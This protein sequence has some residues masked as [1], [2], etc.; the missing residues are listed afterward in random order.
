MAESEPVQKHLKIRGRV[1]GV[2]FRYFTTKKAGEYGVK[3]WVKNMPDGTVE[4]FMSGEKQS[5]ERMK[6]LLHSGPVS[7][8]VTSIDELPVEGQSEAFYDFSVRR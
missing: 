5:V 3:G 4:V 2:G 6:R 7:A 8:H 1:Q